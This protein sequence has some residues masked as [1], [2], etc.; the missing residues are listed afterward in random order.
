[1][2]E[3]TEDLAA[4]LA[5]LERGES[6][7]SRWY[8]DPAITSREVEQ[9]FRKSWH[10]I[11][12]TRELAQLGDYVTGN[13]DEIPV[14][15]IRNQTALAGFVNVCRHRRH[16]VMNGRGN[17]EI[18]QCGY[19]AWAYDLGGCLRRAP[20]SGAEPN[21]RLEDYPL[22]PI[23]VETLGPFA[24]VNIDRNAAPLSSYF[25]DVLNIIG[26][27]GIV[28]DTLE[29]YSREYWRS[30]ANWKSMLENYLECYHCPLAHPAFSAAIDV[31]PENYHLTAHR[32]FL[33][34]V[35]PVRQSALEGKSAVKIYDARGELKQ[36]QY[37]L[38]WPNFT[39]N[40]NPGFANL[41]IDVWLPDGPNHTKGFSEQ[42]FG[43]GVSEE[44]AKELIAL[45]KQVGVED[46]DLTNSVQRGL[47]GGI[48]ERGR[49]L[50]NS[51]HLVIHFQRL[52]IGALTMRSSPVEP[53]SPTRSTPITKTL[54][55]TPTESLVPDAERN[56]AF[57]L[58]LVKIERESEVI[59]SFYFRRID[60]VPLPSWQ[61]GSFCRFASKSRAKPKRSCA[62]I[63][64]QHAQTRTF[65][66]CQS[67]GSRVDKSPAFCM[68]TPN[69]DSASRR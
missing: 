16:E 22:L 28:L 15:V 47:M 68:T 10:Y 64:F 2:S 6:L 59:S 9:I 40:I 43:P 7:P 54:F 21:F 44:F 14:V 53:V 52:V 29:L 8:T 31:I 24:F 11:G 19:H 62:P 5:A 32:W 35:G 33:S 45:N 41:S 42:Y 4:L 27:C 51:E 65:T 69:L 55:A 46:D 17:A 26:E 23:K 61:L 3:A 38:L 60:C 36:A 67:G 37:H 18:M 13:V 49:F 34:Q 58:E 25:G 30:D 48:P 50:T 56:A 20:R 57:E 39:I 1:M 12:P 63:F 66:V